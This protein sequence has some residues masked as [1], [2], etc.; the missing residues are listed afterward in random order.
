MYLVYI[1]KDQDTGEQFFFRLRGIIVLYLFILCVS[2]Y[3][4]ISPS[5]GLSF[6]FT[7]QEFPW[8]H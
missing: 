6:L 2:R 3:S 4:I 7:S 8:K 5:R 1:C